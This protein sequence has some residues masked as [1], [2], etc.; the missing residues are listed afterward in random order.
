MGIF[1]IYW[2]LFID[3]YLLLLFIRKLIKWYYYSY[4]FP[5]ILA[6]YYVQF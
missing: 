6:Q 4:L 1:I 3:Y 5:F 2:L